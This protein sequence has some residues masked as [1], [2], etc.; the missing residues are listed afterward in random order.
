MQA[1]GR[2][3]AFSPNL[4]TGNVLVGLPKYMSINRALYTCRPSSL[5]SSSLGG[6]WAIGRPAALG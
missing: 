6:V 4:C 2:L 1:T 5:Q 3:Y